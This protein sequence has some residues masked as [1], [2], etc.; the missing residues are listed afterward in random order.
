MTKRT[1]KGTTHPNHIYMVRTMLALVLIALFFAVGGGVIYVKN[2]PATKTFTSDL[3]EVELTYPVNLTVE[4]RFNDIKFKNLD[5][6]IRFTKNGTIF[7][8]VETHVDNL[9]KSNKLRVKAR[10]K[11]NLP[12]RGILLETYSGNSNEKSY[13]F[14]KDYAVYY[15]STDDPTLFSDLD[16][17]A[18]SFRILE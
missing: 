16:A 8:D 3:L 4:A 12:I 1:K 5:S 17:I 13:Y 11:V 6:A 15:F 7:S 18:K 9:I 2:Q 10:Q 14:V